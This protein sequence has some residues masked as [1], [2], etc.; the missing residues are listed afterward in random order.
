MRHLSYWSEDTV[1]A[2]TSQF[3]S[4]VIIL[5]QFG[6]FFLAIAFGLS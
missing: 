2:L 1:N 5:C 3:F 4:I 6:H